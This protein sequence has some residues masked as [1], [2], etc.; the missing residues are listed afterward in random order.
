MN[1][2]LIIE[3]EPS[4][5]LGLKDELD[6][7][8]VVTT[9]SD[10]KEGLDS[11][12]KIKPDLILLDILLP[13]INGFELCGTIKDEG[14]DSSI[15]MI[16]ACDQVV[17]KVKG[18]EMG[19]D[20]YITKPFSLKELKA[21]IQAVLRRREV[22]PVEKFDD[23]VL[24]ID[25]KNLYARKKGRELNLSYMEFKLLRYFVFKKGDII[26]RKELLLEVWG[27]QMASFTRT[28]DAHIVGLRKKI[29]KNYITTIHGVGYSFKG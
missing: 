11:A 15:I 1:K 8:Y 20:D 21:R 28:V 26:S 4:I 14:V 12:L 24:Q 22:V 10:G 29:G 17:D 9:A 27:Y 13:D 7:D 18:L 2:I 25:F 23:N 19:A 5:R 3:D 6:K 16:T